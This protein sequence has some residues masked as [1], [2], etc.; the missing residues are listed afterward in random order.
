[1]LL[2]YGS[3]SHSAG[4]TEIAIS[5][6][7]VVAATG[8]REGYVERWAIRGR[9]SG[10]TVS[11]L[12]A[13]VQALESAHSADGQDLLLYLADGTTASAH[14]LRSGET[15]SGVQV[16][17]LSYPDG[18]GAEYATYRTYEVVYAAEV[19]ATTNPGL[20]AWNETLA[21]TGGGPRF[22]FITC[23][24][25]PPVRVVVAEQTPFRCVQSGSALGYGTWPTYSTP[26]FPQHEHRDRRRQDKST[27]QYHGS[28]RARYPIRWS[29]DFEAATALFG[30]P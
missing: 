11:D 19:S 9:L 30:S 29:Y 18:R 5:K 17:S 15:L 13:A 26:L 6:T 14:G 25:G 1:M 3:Y 28:G 12:S 8:V 2:R 24:N 27:P 16:R 21:F 20:I 10:L 4:E 22:E 7:A 23:L